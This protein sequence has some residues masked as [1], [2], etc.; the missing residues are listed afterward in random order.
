MFGVSNVRPP[1]RQTA[2]RYDGCHAI[3]R[4]KSQ[5]PTDGIMSTPAKRQRAQARFSTQEIEA[6]TELGV[7][8]RRIHNRILTEHGA[9]HLARRKYEHHRNTTEEDQSRSLSG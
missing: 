2:F 3:E 7:I 1:S 4:R 6:Y 9:A 5:V 8:L